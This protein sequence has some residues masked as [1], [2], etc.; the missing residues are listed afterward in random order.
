MAAAADA[1]DWSYSSSEESISMLLDYRYLATQQAWQREGLR[2]G[3]PYLSYL[4]VSF[5]KNLWWAN[6]RTTSTDSFHMTTDGLSAH[7]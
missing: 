3:L 4:S 2:E 7:P 5:R 1:P 6:C